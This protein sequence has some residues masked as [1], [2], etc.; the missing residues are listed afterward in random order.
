MPRPRQ[1]RAACAQQ[2]SWRVRPRY[3]LTDEQIGLTLVA[4]HHPGPRCNGEV[5]EDGARPMILR[6][7]D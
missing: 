1:W 7:L 2:R 3:W 6:H 5:D 4:Q